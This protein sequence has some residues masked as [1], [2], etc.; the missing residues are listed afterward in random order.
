MQ[1][2][3]PFSSPPFSLPLPF[4]FSLLLSSL[5][6]LRSS[7]RYIQ[8]EG[9]GERCKLPSGVWGGAPAKVECGAFSLN[10]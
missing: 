4:P 5:P 10:I 9:L 7:P 3:I 6:S 2:S 8:L 1:I